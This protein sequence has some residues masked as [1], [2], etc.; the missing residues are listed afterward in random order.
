MLS[1]LNAVDLNLLKVLNAIATKGQLTAAGEMIGLSQPA[2]SHALKRLRV[3][4]DDELFHRTSSGLQMTGTCQRIMPSVRKIVTECEHVFVTGGVFNPATNAQVFRIGMNDYFSVVLLPP[5]ILRVRELAPNCQIE[6]LHTPRI[7]TNARSQNRIIVQDYLDDGI[8]DVAVM[9]ADKFAP[10]FVCQPLFDEDRV[11]LMSAKNPASQG[12][13]T[14]E[15]FL[16][17]GHVKVSSDPK[18]RGWVDEKLDSMGLERQIVA[19]VPH[20]SS[21]VSIVAQSDL[22]TIMP[23]S[24]ARLFEASHA[25]VLHGPPF[26]IERQATSMIWLRSKQEDSA[27]KW[28]RDQIQHCFELDPETREAAR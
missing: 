8:I 9:T 4:F 15:R 24:V 23:A 19:T 25:L 16:S 10:R 18:R 21:A 28:L 3:I 20:F 6:V 13:L 27:Q 26:S 5:L 17:L 22:V 7:G 2:M 1:S 11:C 14:M 12:P